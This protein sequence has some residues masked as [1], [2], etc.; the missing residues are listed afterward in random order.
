MDDMYTFLVR[1]P[2]SRFPRWYIW[3]IPFWFII[4]SCAV[5][6]VTWLL[7]REIPAWLVVTEVGSLLI[8]AVTITGV[9]GTVRCHAFRVSRHGIWLGVRTTMQRPKLRQVHLAWTDVAQLRMVARRYG[10]LVEITLGPAARIVHR[11]GPGRQA[12]MLLGSLLM[13]IGFGRGRPALTSARDDPPRYLVK[14]CDTTPVELRQV[15][16]AVKPPALMVRTVAK[17]RAL[18]FPAL[19]KQ[20][21]SARPT[22]AA[23]RR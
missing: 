23:A 14:L 12:L 5:L 6:Y 21:S 9:L 10:V 11:P 15:F 20:R 3:L 8:A 16:A 13:P 1:G 19:P 2:S 4:L 7:S 17:P 22:T 18:Q